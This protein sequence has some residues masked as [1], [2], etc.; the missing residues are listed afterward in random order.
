VGAIVLGANDGHVSLW[1]SGEAH[2]YVKSHFVGP[3]WPVGIARVLTS[4]NCLPRFTS[5][6]NFLVCLFFQGDSGGPLMMPMVDD[7]WA[8]IGVVSWGIRCGEP[9]K[10]GLYTRTSKLPFLSSELRRILNFTDTAT[11]SLHGLDPIHRPANLI[12]SIKKLPRKWE[13]TKLSNV[14]IY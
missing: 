13:N 1:G 14:G 7:R 8:A 9:T 10:P 4:N 5:V 6:F 3:L 2:L 11:R 12:H